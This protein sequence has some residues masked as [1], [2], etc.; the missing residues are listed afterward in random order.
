MDFDE[1]MLLIDCSILVDSV[2]AVT[3]LLL[4]NEVSKINLIQGIRAMGTRWV[5]AVRAKESG[6]FS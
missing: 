1:L 4:L 2:A 3:P 5:K 6:K